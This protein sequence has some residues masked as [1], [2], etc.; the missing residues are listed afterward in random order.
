[1]KRYLY[2]AA[3]AMIGAVLRMS[4]SLIS[5]SA[6]LPFFTGTF[7]VN[8]AGAFAAGFFLY[9]IIENRKRGKDFLITG[10]LGSFT[11]FSMLSYE[12]YMLLTIG[13]YVMFIVYIA[14]NL[15]SGLILAA[16]GWQIAGGRTK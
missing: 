5:A 2:I 12:Q 3:G 4:I 14:I 1:M 11:T 10:L 9:R 6:G 16:L 13:D 8:M 7:L 15:L